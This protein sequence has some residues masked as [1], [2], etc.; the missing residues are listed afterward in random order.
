VP[1]ALIEQIRQKREDSSSANPV[2]CV[3]VLYLIVNKPITVVL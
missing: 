1:S 2:I 3:F